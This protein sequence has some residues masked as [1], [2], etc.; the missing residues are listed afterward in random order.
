MKECS[1]FTKN[2]NNKQQQAIL[3]KAIDITN[4]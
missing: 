3:V 1:L 4:S 2:N